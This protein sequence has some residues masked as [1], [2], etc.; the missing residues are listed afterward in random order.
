MA[1]PHIIDQFLWGNKLH[2]L[3]VGPK[4]IPRGKLK[5]EPLAAALRELVDN[6]EMKARSAELGEAVRGENGVEAAVGLIEGVFQKASH[7]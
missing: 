7:V 3:G 4:P 5:V 1:V 2:E 6:P